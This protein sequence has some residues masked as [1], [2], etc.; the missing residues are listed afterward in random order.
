VAGFLAVMRGLLREL[1]RLVARLL[2]AV[3]LVAGVGLL[4]LALTLPLWAFSSY[5]PRAYTWSALGLLGALLLFFLLR[6][7]R[8]RSRL[9]GGLGRMLRL[10]FLPALGR[11]AIVLGSLAALY[12][13]ALLFARGRPAPAASLAAA[14]VLALGYLRLGRRRRE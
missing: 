8:R 6:G 10:H 13:V 4:G 7:L 2:L 9:E 5:L 3:G 12:G 14:L 1:W 11:V